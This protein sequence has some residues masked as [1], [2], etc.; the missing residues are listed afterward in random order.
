MVLS[1][2]II[3]P[4]FGGSAKSA[5]VP[6]YVRA[7]ALAD[8][9]DILLLPRAIA[10][11]VASQKRVESD[12]VEVETARRAFGVTVPVVNGRGSAFRTDFHFFLQ[13]TGCRA[14]FR[15]RTGGSRIETAAACSVT[16]LI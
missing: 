13:G 4:F 3:P 5:T 11:L 6:V 8:F 7:F 1:S 10:Y 12:V 9:R 15:E 2:F 14:F 16:L